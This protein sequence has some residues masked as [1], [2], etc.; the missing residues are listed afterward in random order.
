MGTKSKTPVFQLENITK[1]FGG[2]NALGEVHLRIDVAA[3]L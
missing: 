3:A 2:L 1:R